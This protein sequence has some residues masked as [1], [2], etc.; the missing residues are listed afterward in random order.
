MKRT[1][2]LYASALAS[3]AFLLEWLQYKY[4]TRVFVGE[5]YIIFLAIAFTALGLWAGHKLTRK[6]APARFQRNDAA[7]ASLGISKR[8]FDT[9]ELLA[10]GYSNKEI[11]RSLNISPNTVKTHLGKLYEKLGVQRRTQAVQK[12]K[13]LALIP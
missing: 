1:I 12:A 8:E 5:I 7:I 9:L 2:A 6:P 13:E 3:T 4:I 11:A 10:G